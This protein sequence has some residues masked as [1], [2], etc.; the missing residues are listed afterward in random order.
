MELAKWA[1]VAFSLSYVNT[2]W[3][4]FCSSKVTWHICSG[5]L[6]G[7]LTDFDHFQALKRNDTVVQV[8]SSKA[9]CLLMKQYPD[10][11][12]RKCASKCQGQYSFCS[13]CE[14]Y[15]CPIKYSSQK[16]SSLLLIPISSQSPR[17]LPSASTPQIYAPFTIPLTTQ[18][19]PL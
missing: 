19:Q 5:L 7:D 12:C 3:E 1:V 13:I 15:H 2:F 8:L 4:S 11:P 9:I 17:F 16:L 18:S 10:Y 6:Y 14:H